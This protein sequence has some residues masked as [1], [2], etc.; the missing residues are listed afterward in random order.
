MEI[1]WL[2]DFI[3]LARTRHFSRA[4]DEQHVTQPTF[5]RRIKLL[6]EE[7]GATLINRQTLPLSLTAEGEEFLALCEKITEG[8]RVTRERIRDISAGHDRRIA[9][10]APQSLLAHFLP[11]WLAATG[12]EGRVEPY[13]RATGWVAADYFKALNRGECDLALCYWPLERCDLELDNSA[14]RYRTL[15]YEHLIPVSAPAPDGTPRFTLPASRRS[16]VPWF[17]YPRLGLLGAALKTHL[18]RLPEAPG[19]AVKSENLY[20]AGIKELV[21]LGYGVGW[22]PERSVRRALASGT[23]VRAGDTRWDV[24]LALRLYRHRHHHHA[25]LDVLWGELAATEASR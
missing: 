19:L 23:L 22:L 13:L 9:V 25:E 8:V 15:G 12:L 18:A 7:M 3:A 17:A 2:E 11:E 16:P 1:R 21:A 14:C 20:A 4:A 6:E 24:P 5:S 10:A